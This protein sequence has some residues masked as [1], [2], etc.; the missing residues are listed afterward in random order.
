MVKRLR[1][2]AGGHLTLAVLYIE[3]HLLA[4]HC[5]G[6]S[7]YSRFELAIGEELGMLEH[8]ARVR[9]AEVV[10]LSENVAHDQRAKHHIW[11]RFTPV[12]E[13]HVGEGI[14]LGA[15]GQIDDICR[16]KKAITANVGGYSWFV[17]RRDSGLRGDRPDSGNE[18]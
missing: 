6:D 3:N 14:R 12:A 18:E 7:L 5:A 9:W 10:A 4:M 17:W 13:E 16:A 11:L 8:S 15:S 1:P 2:A